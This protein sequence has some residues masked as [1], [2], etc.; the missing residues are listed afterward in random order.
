MKGQEEP[1]IIGMILIGILAAALL[2]LLIEFVF[3]NMIPLF[4][5]GSVQ[6]ISRDLAGLVTISGIAP[7]KI[8]IDYSPTSDI[9]YNVSIDSRIL[10]ASTLESNPKPM[11]ISSGVSQYA[12]A[13]TAIDNLKTSLVNAKSF[14]IKKETKFSDQTRENVYSVTAK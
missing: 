1:G 14:E 13:K 10:T 8:T 11:T 5:S 4:A 12:T 6:V 3:S 2:Y 7:Y 9:I